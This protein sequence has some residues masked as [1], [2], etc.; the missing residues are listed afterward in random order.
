MLLHSLRLCCFALSVLLCQVRFQHVASAFCVCCVYT[1]KASS[2]G[3]ADL[4]LHQEAHA[5][6]YG[7]TWT[8]DFVEIDPDT[9]ALVQ[10]FGTLEEGLNLNAGAVDRSGRLLTIDFAG[11]AVYEIYPRTATLTKVVDIVGLLVDVRG[12]AI[13]SQDTLYVCGRDD[14]RLPSTIWE[15]NLV[16]GAASLR[17]RPDNYC[18][19]LAFDNDDVLYCYH[20]NTGLFQVD[21]MTGISTNVA[22]Y[23]SIGIRDR[24]QTL[25]MDRAT[26][27]MLAARESLFEIDLTDYSIT[28]IGP[29]YPGI[30]IRGLFWIVPRRCICD[31][32]PFPLLRR[33]CKW[34]LC[35]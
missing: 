7:V 2:H 15:I 30:D 9:G 11:T 20:V 23:P 25:E 8:G 22:D 35:R 33:K 13:D 16:T 28:E 26:G 18:Q 14:T 4:S 3:L 19:A 21:T 6:L 27:K 1:L 5:E 32:I 29:I 12:I 24:P 34:L 17:F 10:S 31:N